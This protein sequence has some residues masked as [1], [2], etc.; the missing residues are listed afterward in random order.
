MYAPGLLGNHAV[1]FFLDRF[2]QQAWLGNT[3]QPWRA[4]R[5]GAKR[6]GRAILIDSGRLRRSIRITQITNGIVKIGTDVPYAKA[7]NN[8]FKGIVN[9]PA[10][11]RNKYTKERLGTGRF[12]KTGKERTRLVIRAAGATTV[13]AH[14]KRV[15]LP[16]RKFMGNSPYLTT[17]LKRILQ[18]ELMKGLR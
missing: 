17:Q 5:K 7:H 18:A 1:N 4:R 16:A 11:T 8:G 10:H 12:T 13:K 6:P 3:L 2:K 14:T 9:V 15:N